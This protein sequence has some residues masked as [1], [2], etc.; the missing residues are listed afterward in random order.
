MNIRVKLLG[1]LSTCYQGSYTPS[2]LDLEVPA[3]LTVA[4]LV[5]RI[6]I[7]KEQVAIVSIN[8]ILAKAD[9]QVPENAIVKLIQPITGG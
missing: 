9:D 4:D 2:G 6:G 8:G 1:T 3:S 7:P 5:A